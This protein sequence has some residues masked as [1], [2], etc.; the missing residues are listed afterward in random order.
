MKFP[1]FSC[2]G[3][4]AIPPNNATIFKILHVVQ[5]VDNVIYRINLYPLDSAN[6]FPNTYPLDKYFMVFSYLLPI[7][8]V[9]LF[10]S[11]MV[12]VVNTTD[13]LAHV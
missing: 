13:I 12:F 3:F 8:I 11:F 2:K 6:G 1:Q 7:L 10:H 9:S 5:K 4:V